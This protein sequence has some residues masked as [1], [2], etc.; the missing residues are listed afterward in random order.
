MTAT[1]AQYIETFKLKED[2]MGRLCVRGMAKLLLSSIEGQAP[3]KYE[4]H[5][6]ESG[7]VF[8]P[9]SDLH[10][11]FSHTKT[12]AAVAVSLSRCGI[13]V[14]NN[15]R[16]V[17]REQISKRFFT[18]DEHKQVLGDPSAFFKIWTAKEAFLKFEGTGIDRPLKDIQV[19]SDFK[20]VQYKNRGFTL[21]S[22]VNKQPK[23]TTLS[24]VGAEI[25]REIEIQDLLGF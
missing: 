6:R 7:E 17:N 2:R 16:R 10:F 1:S 19:S 3:W 9:Q 14:E 12:H 18:P 8:S 15:E 24:V 21:Y 5:K 20:Q 4:I 11:S 13:D 23:S 22:R 25:F